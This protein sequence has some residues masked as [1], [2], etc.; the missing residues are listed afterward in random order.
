MK[1]F[2]CEKTSGEV[3]VKARIYERLYILTAMCKNRMKAIS[4]DRAR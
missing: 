4:S 1:D 2:L 3:L